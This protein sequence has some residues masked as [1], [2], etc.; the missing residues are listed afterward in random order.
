MDHEVSLQEVVVTTDTATVEVVTEFDFDAHSTSAVTGFQRV[1]QEYAEFAESVKTLLGTCIS[2]AGIPPVQSM[3]ARAKTLESLK[4][5]AAKP[6]GDNPNRP[7]YDK[8]L[9]QITDLAGVRVI[10]FFLSS[11]SAIEDVIQ[12]EFWIHEKTDKSKLLEQEERL[13]YHSV[14][15]IV[16][17]R[18]SR[19]SL[20]EYARFRELCV[21]V[22]VRTILQHAWA[23]IEHDVQYKAKDALPARIR[24]RFMTLA[25]MLEIA[26]REFQ[27]IQEEDAHLRALARSDVAAGR[28]AE[29]EITSDALKAY[30]DR[31][32]GSDGR[33]S[34]FSYRYTAQLL[35]SLGFRNLGQVDEA[36]KDISHDKISRIIY[37]GRQGQLSRFEDSLL[38]AMG[39]NYVKRHPWSHS[40][41]QWYVPILETRLERLRASN[42]EIGSYCPG[43]VSDTPQAP[44]P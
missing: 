36:I 23:E 20:P 15:Y 2:Q 29:V 24:R 19:Y 1:R 9:I 27:G 28:L 13:G 35:E 22:Q 40:N 43:D 37:G 21:E 7:K 41:D 17:L 8:P 42:V 4:K 16:G 6:S 12:R 39:E 33:M 32:L 25:G 26:D 5:K 11:V 30:V 10:T 3:E 44:E 14:H 34:D 38:V 18:E 31:R